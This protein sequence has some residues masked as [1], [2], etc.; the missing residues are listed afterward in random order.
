MKIKRFVEAS[1]GGLYDCLIWIG[2]EKKPK[3]FKRVYIDNEQY[4]LG[5]IRLTDE[6]GESVLFVKS[7]IRRWSY[8][9][10]KN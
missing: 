5:N 1:F 8:C 3:Q 10:P 9:P 6:K 7:D 4:K 2:D